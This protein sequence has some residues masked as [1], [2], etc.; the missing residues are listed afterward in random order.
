MPDALALA[1][2]IRQ[3][4]TTAT[5]AMEAALDAADQ[6][7]GIGAVRHVD[8]AMG[9]AAAAEIDA[10][11]AAGD[12]DMLATPFLGVPFLM[13]DLGAAAAGLPKVAGSRWVERH[14]AVP[15]VDDDLTTR[16]RAAGLVPFGLTTV[17]EF[18][19][20]LSSEP[21][22]GPTAR[23]PLDERRTPGGSSGGAAAAVAA[24]IVA[25]AHATD[26]AGSTRVPAACCGLVGLKT[27]RGATPTGPEFG[28]HLFGIAS[29]LVVSRS[30]RDSAAALDALAGAAEGPEPDPALGLPA[31]GRLETPVPPLSIGCVFDAPDGAPVAPERRAALESAA[32]ALETLGHRLVPLQPAGFADW[33]DTSDRVFA[34]IIAANFARNFA[35]VRIAAGELEPLSAAFIAAGEQMTAGELYTAVVEAAKV[36]QGVARLF[37]NVDVLLTPMLSGPPLAIGSFPLGHSDIALQ[38]RRMRDFAPYAALANVAGVPAITLPHG[39][40]AVGLPLPVQLVGPMGADALLLRLARSLEKVAPFAHRFPIAGLPA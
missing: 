20:A 24:G 13:K 39:V 8:A 2:A 16:F 12:P 5:A 29:E 11:I 19:L 4:R 37:R 40:D 32:A 22:I 9:L 21:A 17:P 18:G 23:N 10:R 30:V 33:L 1:D 6:F 3:R 7:R 27:T 26:A 36:A 28:N 31:R 25:V 38:T 14:G 34:A 35:G 15:A